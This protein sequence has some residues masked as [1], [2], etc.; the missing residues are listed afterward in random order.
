[1]AAIGN[2]PMN[3]IKILH[4]QISVKKMAYTIAKLLLHYGNSR[5]AKQSH[6]KIQN[7]EAPRRKAPTKQEAWLQFRIR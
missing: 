1:M 7:I 6:F 3:A 5:G 4:E 2:A